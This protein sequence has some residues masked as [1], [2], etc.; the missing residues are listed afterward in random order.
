M[1]IVFIILSFTISF[2]NSTIIHNQSI[3]TF[4]VSAKFNY[5]PLIILS[6]GLLF[7][8][9][10]NQDQYNKIINYIIITIKYVLVFSLLRYVIIHTI[11]NILDWIGFA[12]P[13]DSI[14]WTANTPPPSL[15]LTEFYS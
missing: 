1:I 4:L 9:F 14:E 13:G 10:I 12:Q 3:I 7:S 2:L 15:Y 5:I 11:P 6:S 8:Q